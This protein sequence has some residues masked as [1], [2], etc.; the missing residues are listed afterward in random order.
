MAS[1][2]DIRAGRAYVELY[3]K[4]SAFLKGLQNIQKDLAKLG[5][6]ISSLGKRMMAVGAAVVTPLMGTAAAFAH[7]GDTF[8]KMSARTG[9]SVEALSGLGFAAQQSGANLEA[10]ETSVRR[11]QRSITD[12]AAG[13]KESQEAFQA[14]GLSVAALATLTP[15]QQFLEIAE[16]LSRVPDP[17]K[18]AALAMDVFGKSGT[19]MLPM[20]A[21]GKAGIKKLTDEAES[22]GLI[23]SGETAKA[24]AELEDAFGRLTSAGKA[25]AISFGASLA[26]ML[27]GLATSIA[28]GGK[29]VSGWANAHKQAVATAL[30]L[31]T[32]IMGL[33]AAVLVAGSAISFMGS[34]VGVVVSAVQMLGV[35]VGM[36]MG[37]VTSPITLV[38]AGMAGL[39]YYL[40]TTPTAAA[41]LGAT[42]SGALNSVSEAAASLWT[43]MKDGFAN[44]VEDGSSAFQ[45]IAASIAAGDIQGAIAVALA[46]VK[47]EWLRLVNWATSKWEEFRNFWGDLT[48]GIAI[49]FINAVAQ[50]KSV[51]AEAVA[52]M[53]K[54]WNSF[55]VSS[56][57]EKIANV[58]A[59]IFAKLEGVDVEDA[60]R[61][62]AED[63]NRGRANL[64]SQNAEIDAQTAQ[65]KADVERER[66]AQTSDVA[67]QNT[68]AQEDRRRQTEAAE[69]ALADA[70]AAFELSK[71]KAAEEV[72]R[73]TE[74]AK[75]R[76]A[77]TKPGE[78]PIAPATSAITSAGT[79][80][81]YAAA[82][83]AGG[84]NA[85]E[86]TAT[87]T[88]RMAGQMAAAL[89]IHV[90][91]LA[92]LRALAKQMG[93][94]A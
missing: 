34:A 1:A 94:Q 31:G 76:G 44:V 42:F 87:A 89:G 45:S 37:V 18:R 86:R 78:Q 73:R 77:M 10:V 51:W 81:G 70:K 14:L 92:E 49:T 56:F 50:I 83:M 91:S 66:Q 36:V 5:G 53:Q 15:E 64:P 6:G 93:Y 84:G 90:Q 74:Q 57:T 88:M 4:N 19:S 75:N 33:G 85:A 2:S 43:E 13:T 23:L 52:F 16:A 21:E 59:P 48:S 12:A 17:T 20:I 46:F 63:M 55:S 80:S 9:M 29:V 69:K 61:T 47:L 67:R 39:A 25:V 27:T 54:A 22:L 35:V 79:F 82:A 8:D 60:R 62:L 26:P 30:M 65:Y 72:Q 28:R 11:M 38:L 68:V 58:I 41:K 3:V 32:T 7:V 24:G 71:G 40:A